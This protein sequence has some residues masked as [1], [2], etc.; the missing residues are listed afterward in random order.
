MPTE[1][2]PHYISQNATGT[3]LTQ[4]VDT[5]DYPH[6]GLIKALNQMAAGNVVVKTGADFDINQTGSNIVVTAGKIL[7]NGKYIEVS[8]DGSGADTTI[9]DSTLNSTW[10]KG[11]HLL[12]VADGREGGETADRL[13]LRPPTANE[14]VPE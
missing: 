13:Y 9:A 5:V 7:R 4:P 11:Y 6:S 1:P 2:N 8:S 3:S 10:A 14:R 12:V